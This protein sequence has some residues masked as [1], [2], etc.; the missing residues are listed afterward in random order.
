M[1]SGCPHRVEN[2]TSSVAI[3]ANYV[4]LSNISVVR[5]ELSIQALVDCRAEDLLRQLNAPDFGAK[6][7]LSSAHLPWTQFKCEHNKRTAEDA[8]QLQTNEQE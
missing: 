1:P 3:S 5:R 8:G 6:T 4:D 7:K 2:L